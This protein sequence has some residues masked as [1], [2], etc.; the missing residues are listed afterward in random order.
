VISLPLEEVLQDKRCAVILNTQVQYV[1]AV[2]STIVKVGLES[3]R[4]SVERERILSEMAAREFG[5]RPVK[6]SSEE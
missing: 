1:R 3:D 5:S 4:L 6:G 2:L